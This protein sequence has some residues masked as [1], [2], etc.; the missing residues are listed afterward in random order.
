MQPNF[1]PGFYGPM[2]VGFCFFGRYF[3]K[4]DMPLIMPYTRLQKSLQI[5]KELLRQHVP[6]CKVLAFGSRVTGTTSRYSDLDLAIVCS[7]SVDWRRLE[8]LK[9]AF[10]ESDLPIMVDVLDWQSLSESF[11]A[12]IKRQCETVQG[13]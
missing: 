9:D 1:V 4:N 5:V 6:E 2:R 10:S 8:A 13:G 12:I 11:Q 7:V 3:L